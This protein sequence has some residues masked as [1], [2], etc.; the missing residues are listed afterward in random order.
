MS[1]NSQDNLQLLRKQ[2]I[3]LIGIGVAIVGI[4]IFHFILALVISWQASS[5]LLWVTVGITCIV[6]LLRVGH[7]AYQENSERLFQKITQLDS[8]ARIGQ[9]PIPADRQMILSLY[10]G[11]SAIPFATH[12]EAVGIYFGINLT[13]TVAALLYL[14][15]SN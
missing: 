2:S 11:A 14:N 8:Q 7:A 9:P 5:L 15:F 13:I 10:A 12:K 3:L 6:F 4:T 1:A